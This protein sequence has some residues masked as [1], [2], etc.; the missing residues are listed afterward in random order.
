MFLVNNLER[1]FVNPQNFSSSKLNLNP[2]LKAA[3]DLLGF[4]RNVS[5][6]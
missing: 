5:S 4:L 6:F 1:L 2:N 3:S